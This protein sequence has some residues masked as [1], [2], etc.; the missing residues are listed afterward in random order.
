MTGDVIT[1]GEGESKVDNHKY[2][3]SGWP[4]AHI[5]KHEGKAIN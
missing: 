5:S 3:G 4:S 2:V 1:T